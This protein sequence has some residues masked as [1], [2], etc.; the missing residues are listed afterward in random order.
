LLI[1]RSG[2]ARSGLERHL[3][4]PGQRGDAAVD[5][6]PA[7]A[8]FRRDGATAAPSVV[9]YDPAGHWLEP[10]TAHHDRL[11][12]PVTPE[13][14]QI[15]HSTRSKARQTGQGNSRVAPATLVIGYLG[16]V[17][18]PLY[19]AYVLFALAAMS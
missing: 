6:L 17:L 15:G 1:Y 7:A 8:G 4:V 2:N 11:T 18:A 5:R 10:S 14:Q 16:L 19:L 13:G 9:L 12:E 3:T